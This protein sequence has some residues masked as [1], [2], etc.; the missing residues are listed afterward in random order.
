M[1]LLRYL[2]PSAIAYLATAAP[3]P[4]N[5][6]LHEKRESAPRAWTK[7]DRVNP[8]IVLPVR[9]GLTQS[10]LENGPSLLDEVY[11]IYFTSVI[12]FQMLSWPLPTGVDCSYDQTPRILEDNPSCEHAHGFTVRTLIPRNTAS[13][14]LLKR[15]MTF[16][17]L[18]KTVSTTSVN[19][20]K[21]LA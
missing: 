3:A 8:T 1:H 9:I 17:L 5:H 4:V 13:I 2:V 11:V 20:S 7:R 12:V 19:G 10:N 16:S 18:L 6:V 14:T 15:S 21:P